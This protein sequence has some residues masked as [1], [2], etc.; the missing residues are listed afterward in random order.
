MTEI[1][2]RKQTLLK[3]NYKDYPEFMFAMIA[4][5]LPEHDGVYLRKVAGEVVFRHDKD[6]STY[7]NGVLHSY[8][9]D[10]AIINEYIQWYKNGKRHREG[11]L[12]AVISEYIEEWWMNGKRHREG[13]KPAVISGDRQEWYKNGKL[14]RE[15]D[16]PAV[17]SGDRQEWWMNGKRHREGDKP[18]I[19]SGGTVIYLQMFTQMDKTR[20]VEKWTS[21]QGR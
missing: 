15:G 20:V 21:P 14:H 1:K 17:I 7:K 10:P 4:A 6:G 8:N 12:P 18:V 11:D 5:Y 3:I 9:D 2:N 19:I 13:D 16:L